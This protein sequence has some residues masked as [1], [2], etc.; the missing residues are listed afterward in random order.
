MMSEQKTWTE[1]DVF[2]AVW[3]GMESQGW[4]RSTDEDGWC[5]YRGVDGRRCA[6]G[7]L[8]PDDLYRPSMEVSGVDDKPVR[9]VLRAIGVENISFLYELQKAHDGAPSGAPLREE[10]RC[11][12]KEHG[13][14]IPGER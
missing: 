3:A 10:F 12:A 6:V 2:D 8:I 13:L 14:T 11:V 9:T 1:Q 4:K 5:M 7:H